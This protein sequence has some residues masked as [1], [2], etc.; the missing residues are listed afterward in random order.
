MFLSL[1]SH[2]SLS[3]RSSLTRYGALLVSNMR[4]WLASSDSATSGHA[5]F[6]DSCYHHCPFYAPRLGSS[7]LPGPGM[8]LASDVLFGKWIDDPAA[9]HG[10]AG[11]VHTDFAAPPVNCG[12]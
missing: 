6:V 4:L 11:Q 1:S 12:V 5:A 10:L 7:T 8:G 9:F 2:A 3:S